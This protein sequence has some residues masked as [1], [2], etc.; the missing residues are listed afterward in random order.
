MSCRVFK[1]R[2]WREERK[3]E[4]EGGREGGRRKKGDLVFLFIS[5]G[6]MM[7][8]AAPPSAREAIAVGRSVAVGR[9]AEAARPVEGG[10]G[11][12]SS[13]TYGVFTAVALP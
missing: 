3:E 2:K 7:S 6:W 10:G 4:T 12:M 1:S 11:E 9:A 8:V 5:D 13:A